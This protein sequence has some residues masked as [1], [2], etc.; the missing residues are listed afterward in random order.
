MDQAITNAVASTT[1][2]VVD[3]LTTNI[4]VVMV[5][6]AGLVALGII[7]HLISRLVGRRA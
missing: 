6:F 4:P 5:V 1:D 3:V 2:T 7:L